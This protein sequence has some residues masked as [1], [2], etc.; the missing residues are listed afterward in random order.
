MAPFMEPKLAN[1][2]CGFREVHSTQ[3]ALPR[4]TETIRIHID[5]SGVRGMVLMDLSQAYDCLSH[6]LL[7]A[8]MEAYGFSRQ[9]RTCA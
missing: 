3:H 4:V 2:I 5:Q 1:I 7:L 8:K 6:D 9:C